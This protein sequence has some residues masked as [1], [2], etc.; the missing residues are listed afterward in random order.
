MQLVF[1]VRTRGAPVRG[2]WRAQTIIF[3]STLSSR[4][5]FLFFLFFSHVIGCPPVYTFAH[6]GRSFLPA[7]IEPPLLVS[8]AGTRAIDLSAR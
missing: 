3:S 8:R 4:D 1:E 2:M 7:R 5:Y 6:T